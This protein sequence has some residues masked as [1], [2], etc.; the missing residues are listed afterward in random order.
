MNHSRS[1][2]IYSLLELGSI[3]TISNNSNICLFIRHSKN[4]SRAEIPTVELT[5]SK[6]PIPGGQVIFNC[7]LNTNKATIVSVVHFKIDLPAFLQLGR[8]GTV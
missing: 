5:G 7:K 1:T 3:P 4:Q 2:C 6:L 8:N